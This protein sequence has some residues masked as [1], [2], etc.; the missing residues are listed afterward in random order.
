MEYSASGT[1]VFGAAQT[2][3]TVHLRGFTPVL[4]SRPLAWRETSDDEIASFPGRSRFQFLIAY[5]MQK[6]RGK[7]WEKESR[8]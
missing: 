6:R 3:F 5:C 8:A 7:A 4:L 2:V 1:T